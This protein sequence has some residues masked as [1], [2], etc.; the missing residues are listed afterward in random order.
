MQFIR[1]KMTGHF[2]NKADGRLFIELGD[3]FKPIIY[4][5]TQE[6][7]KL[8]PGL[9]DERGILGDFF[10]NPHNDLFYYS[11]SPNLDTITAGAV[12]N[13]I[14]ARIDW[15][16]FR[17][18]LTKALGGGEWSSD[19]HPSEQFMALLEETSPLMVSDWERKAAIALQRS[20]LRNM[21]KLISSRPSVSLQEVAGERE[22]FEVSEEVQLLDSLGM[23]TREFEIYCVETNQKISCVSN[24]A[25][26]EDAAQRGFKCFHCGRPISSERIVQSLS[27]TDSG[28]R[29]AAKNMWLAYLVGASLCDEGV[30]PDHIMARSEHNAD[31]VEV[32]ADVKGS[33]MMFSVSETELTPDVAF[34]FIMRSRFFNPE[35]G[36]L[37]TPFKV[38]PNVRAVLESAGD[39]LSIVEGLET[40]PDVVR[41]GVAKA[42]N[43]ILCDLLKHFNQYTQIDIGSWVSDYML[44]NEDIE[45]IIGNI[46]TDVE[47]ELDS[48][49]LLQDKTVTLENTVPAAPASD[50]SDEIL[51]AA[52]ESGQSAGD[53]DLK[54]KADAEVPAE[55]A[56]DAAVLSETVS[57]GKKGG[58]SSKESRKNARPEK[59][60]FD[61]IIE[62]VLTLLPGIIE[63]SD[64]TDAVNAQLNSV[65]GMEGCSIMVATPDGLPFLGNLSTVDDSDLVAALQLDLMQNISNT[66]TENKLGALKSVILCSVGNTMRVYFSAD[67]LTVITHQ[68]MS[69]IDDIVIKHSKSAP[70]LRRALKGLV[71]LPGVSK[72]MLLTVEGELLQSVGFSNDKYLAPCFAYMMNDVI[73]TFC[74]DVGMGNVRACAIRTDKAFFQVMCLGEGFYLVSELGTKV[75]EY[76]WRRDLPAEA[77]FVS[78]NV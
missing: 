5:A 75:P 4:G 62:N 46:D 66:L 30:E 71:S 3:S 63:N 43:K 57:A 27:I 38:D 22:L 16:K 31:I 37:V 26:L 28:C 29:L 24:L 9:L 64:N 12:C 68:K 23:I 50:S 44:N 17:E 6:L 18:A 32:F 51:P 39:R 36:Y 42:S 41:Q 78:A 55:S 52:P 77:S 34:R 69:E 72:S 67:D 20:N 53:D 61:G 40:L 74:E 48:S 10:I 58:R 13:S 54:T 33:L 11:F 7:Y 70:N 76:V 49:E 56:A 2:K 73:K 1:E 45:A 14:R 59:A 65:A 35:W 25:A 21:I 19:I 47:L 60:G 15:H 8:L